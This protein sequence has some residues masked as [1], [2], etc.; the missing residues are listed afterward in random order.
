M[1]GVARMAR[2]WT[3]RV[4]T[5]AVVLPMLL[6]GCSEKHQASQSL[7]PT[8]TSAS[9]SSTL[10]PVGP[11]GFPVP[12]QARQRSAEGATAFTEY[13]VQLMSRQAEHLDSQ[14]LR[15]LS[16]NCGACT[17]IADS[18][19]QVKASGQR[20]QGGALTLAGR[21]S[22]TLTE[23]GAETAFVLDQAAVSV[24]NSDG[25]EVPGRTFPAKRL[26]GGLRLTWDKEKSNWLVTQLDADPA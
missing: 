1:A 8:K 26:T 4:A 17:A 21:P 11:S 9:A 10:P 15:Q 7:P 6:A 12:I 16:L 18:Y 14:P 24:L 25:A 2:R 19:D 13:F 5:C 23:D 3:L 20:Y 22:A